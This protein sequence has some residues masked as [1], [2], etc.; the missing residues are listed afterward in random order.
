VGFD[1][2]AA[3]LVID[4]G[5][6]DGLEI[7]NEGA[8]AP[9]VE[10]LQALADA[11]DGLV[12]VEGVLKEKLVD[13]GAGGIGGTAGGDGLF[14]VALGVDVETAAR[15]KNSLGGGDKAGNVRRALVERDHERLSAGGLK[16]GEIL[17]E[18]ALVVFDV[19]GGGL[20]DGDADGHAE[21][22]L[23]EDWLD[24]TG[25]L[26]MMRGNRMKEFLG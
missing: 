7:L 9:D 20:G 19:G 26:L 22:S 15:K 2:F 21:I 23:S 4:L 11:E 17:R 5:V 16:R 1:D 24:G 25:G 12:Q 6:K 18:G 13:G 3:G 8:V 14:S 10:A